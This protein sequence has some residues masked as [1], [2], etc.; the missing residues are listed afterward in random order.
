[1]L[2]G[3]AQLFMKGAKPHLVQ[4]KDSPCWVDKVN[5]VCWCLVLAL[6]LLLQDGKKF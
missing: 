3:P 1:M 2:A 5:I 4:V 6:P